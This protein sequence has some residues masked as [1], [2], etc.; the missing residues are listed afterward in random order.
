MSQESS[1]GRTSVPSTIPGLP[2]IGANPIAR[3]I[4]S[5]LQRFGSALLRPRGAENGPWK[6]L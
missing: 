5:R 4:L 6:R 1:P 2:R 3:P